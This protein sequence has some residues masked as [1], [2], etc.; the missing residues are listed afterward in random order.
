M[1]V[2]ADVPPV[3]PPVVT[4]SR[5]KRESL[6]EP[7]KPKKCARPTAKSSVFVNTTDDD[8]EPPATTKA[9]SATKAKSA[10]KAT[11]AAKATKATSSATK[12][13]RSCYKTEL[14]SETLELVDGLIEE[15]DKLSRD[16]IQ[17]HVD[18]VRKLLASKHP[19][20][21]KYYK[22][23]KT[24]SGKIAGLG[25]LLQPPKDLKFAKIT[26]DFCKVN[27]PYTC[28]VME[29]GTSCF[30]CNYVRHTKC[31]VEGEQVS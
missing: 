30:V 5:R 21:A 6:D 19:E 29:D 14:L 20:R 4:G 13:P 28:W 11:S 7:P 16:D 27:C 26:C 22:P 8:Y 2:D 31:T 25:K 18:S 23:S 17:K 9:T 12:P 15:G 1:D 3:V 10:T 24:P